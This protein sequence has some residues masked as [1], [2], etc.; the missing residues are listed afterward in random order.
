MSPCHSRAHAAALRARTAAGR[1]AP[2]AARRAVRTGLRVSSDVAKPTTFDTSYVRPARTGIVTIRVARSDRT[3]AP[4]GTRSRAA[5]AIVVF[6]PAV[7]TATSPA[8]IDSGRSASPPPSPSTSRTCRLPDQR[9]VSRSRTTPTRCRPVERHVVAHLGC[10]PAR[11]PRR[12]RGEHAP[13]QVE[14]LAIVAR[15]GRGVAPPAH[16]HVEPRPARQLDRALPLGAAGD[17][18]GHVGVDAGDVGLG[19][20]RRGHAAGAVRRDPRADVAV[21]EV[22]RGGGGGRRPLGRER[23]ARRGRARRR[24]RQQRR[25]REQAEGASHRRDVLNLSTPITGRSARSSS[26]SANASRRTSRPSALP[27]AAMIIPWS[28]DR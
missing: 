14:F 26:R 2:S 4:A 15:V 25:E 18:I 27:S 28:S 3:R 19:R 7:R 11:R 12:G 20:D 17:R 23:P 9:G 1:G 21:A 16:D 5:W 6:V 24:G 10:A 8:R 22:R 13:A